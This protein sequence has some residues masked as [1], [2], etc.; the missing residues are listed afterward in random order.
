M[1]LSKKQ[2]ARNWTMIFFAPEVYDR[3]NF[4]RRL[5]GQ[6]GGRG[7]GASIDRL[8]QAFAFDPAQSERAE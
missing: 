7:V 5:D 2:S 8:S 6:Q 3:V 1:E 4:V